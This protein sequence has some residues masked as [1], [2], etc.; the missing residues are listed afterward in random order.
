MTN[1]AYRMRALPYWAAIVPL[2]TVNVCYVVAI[3]LDHLPACIPYLTGCTSVS[4]T[5][6]IAPESLIFR[7][8]MLP[9]ALIVALFWQ[10]CVTF[11][12]LGGQ[13][14]SRLVTLQVLGFIAALSLVVYA[15]TLGF[16]DNA[17]RQLRR[18]GII[19]FALGTFTAEVSLIIFYRPMRIATTEKLWRWLIILCVALPLL[20]V[21]SEIAKW[22]GAPRHGANN[23]VA[24]NAFL[25][26]S[27]YYSVVARIWWQHGF[28]SQF[29]ITSVGRAASPR[30]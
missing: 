19:G 22:A 15:V 20:S 18:V 25:V 1:H 9:S 30:E 14:G 6:R 13:S 11:L 4:S 23:T 3:G 8:G 26:A 17:Y 7:A 24:W 28:S 29:T 2:V 10:R 27:A 12:R 21:G 5:G 16:E